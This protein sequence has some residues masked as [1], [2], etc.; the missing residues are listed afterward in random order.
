MAVANSLESIKRAELMQTERRV[1][2]NETEEVPRGSSVQVRIGRHRNFYE[3]PSDFPVPKDVA[4]LQNL[5][6]PHN[7]NVLILIIESIERLST[8][9]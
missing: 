3:L 4:T 2:A 9:L 5:K 1:R 7:N 6:T 8:R